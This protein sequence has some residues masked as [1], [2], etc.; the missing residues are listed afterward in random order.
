MLPSY[1][2]VMRARR[3]IS[4]FGLCS[5]LHAAVGVAGMLLAMV[6]A[7]AGPA[8][9]ASFTI[10]AQN[11]EYVAPGGGSA[12]TV[13]I[14]STVTWVAS[15]DPHSVTSGA[16]GS[17]DHRFPDHPASAGLLLAGDSFT[18]T[19]SSAG[20]FPYFCEVH[21]EQ[22]SGV[23]TVVSTAT[24][25]PTPAPTPRATPR[26]T[27]KPTQAPSPTPASAPTVQPSLTQSPT[28]M[29]SASPTDPEPTAGPSPSAIANPT[30]STDP[31]AGDGR[32]VGADAIPPIV[33][34][35]ALVIILAVGWLGWRR[36][37]GRQR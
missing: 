25:P 27:P 21:P 32:A 36:L 8:T 3:L 34:G 13:P 28:A 18:T 4:H 9:G 35:A 31:V 37:S 16:P 6:I 33:A 26:A 2:E 30:A 22:M 17:I 15:G 7:A 10:H 19:F 11:Y 1:L 23:I 24:R 20:T 12:L 5:R 29:P 14:G